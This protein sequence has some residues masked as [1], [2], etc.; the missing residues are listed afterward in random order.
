M[1]GTTRVPGDKSISHRAIMFGAMASGISHVEGWLPAGDTTATLNAVRQLG[2]TIEQPAPTTLIIHG[3]AFRPPDGPLNLVNAG[4]GIRLLTGIMAGQPFAS[5]LDGSGQLRRRPMRRVTEPL[6]L[7]GANVDSAGGYPPLHIEPA[8]LHGIEYVLPIASAQVKSAILLA[9][10]F[11]EGPT[12]VIESG[13]GRDHTERLLAA[14]G[15]DLRVGGGRITLNPGHPLQALDMTIPGDF[16]SAAFLIVAASI[17]AGS[18]V[19]LE[20]VSLN[21]TRTGLVDV[22]ATMGANATM[23]VVG[24]AGGDPVGRLVVR[25]ADLHGIEVGGETV[26]RMID[27]FPAFMIAA[28]C[29]EGQTTVRDARELRVKETDRIAVMANELRKMGAVILEQDDGFQLSGRQSLHGATLDGHDDHRIAMSLAIAAL[30][31]R[32][33]SVIQGAG[34]VADSFPGFAATLARLGVDVH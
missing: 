32:G 3:G 4:T 14:M 31:A 20:H 26:V 16:S 21:P 2:I 22:L 15:A 19:T 10:L 29:A 33:P 34:C 17:L 30:V 28:L 8:Q 1:K 27:E 23:E 12:T 11:A 7:M 13:P 24:E 25:A 5:T 6:V 9:G 18:A